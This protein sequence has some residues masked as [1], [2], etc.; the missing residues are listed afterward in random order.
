MVELTLDLYQDVNGKELAVIFLSLW[1]K[2]FAEE[3]GCAI[4]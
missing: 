2:W 3:C 1:G 4:S